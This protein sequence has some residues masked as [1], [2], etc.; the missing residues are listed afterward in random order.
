MPRSLER[1]HTTAAGLKPGTWESVV[2]LARL[3]EAE[4]D[5]GSIA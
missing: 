2:A 1:A 5:L 3:A 4:Q